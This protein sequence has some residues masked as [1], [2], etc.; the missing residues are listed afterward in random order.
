MPPTPRLSGIQKQ[1]LALYRESLRA[2]RRV[3]SPSGALAA[4]AYARQEFRLAAATVDRMDF[5]RVEH[6]LRAGRKKLDALSRADVSNFAL[7]RS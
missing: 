7:S 5:Q 2:A 1:V 6:L 3:P 4:T